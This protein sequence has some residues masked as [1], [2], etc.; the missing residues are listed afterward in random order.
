MLYALSSLLF[1]ATS[2]T[3]LDT[4]PADMMAEMESFGEDFQLLIAA[5]VIEVFGSFRDGSNG[6]DLYTVPAGTTIHGQRGISDQGEIRENGHQADP[7]SEC[8]IDEEV[9]P[10]DPA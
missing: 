9:I 5:K 1:S 7:R 2:S 10:S 3:G 6:A 8:F 4:N